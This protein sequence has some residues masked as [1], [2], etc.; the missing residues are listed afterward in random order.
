[1]RLRQRDQVWRVD[2]TSFDHDLASGSA[3]MMLADD[4]FDEP[5]AGSENAAPDV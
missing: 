1:V 2:L 5:D 4:Y 3:F